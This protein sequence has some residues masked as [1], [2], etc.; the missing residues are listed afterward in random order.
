VCVCVC[1]C[2]WCVCVCVCVTVCMCVCVCMCVLV[3]ECVCVCVCVCV[4]TFRRIF[5]NILTTLIGNLIIYAFFPRCNTIVLLYQVIRTKN[6]CCNIH[7]PNFCLLVNPIY[8]GEL[9]TNNK[10]SLNFRQ[11]WYSLTND[12]SCRINLSFLCVSSLSF[13]RR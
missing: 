13:I 9:R 2:V 4:W 11:L 7:C 1:V 8:I 5:R 3:L 12:I 6:Y 10:K